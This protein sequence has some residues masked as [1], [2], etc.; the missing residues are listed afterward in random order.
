[1]CFRSFRNLVDCEETR[2]LVST[3]T[4][5]LDLD[6][7]KAKNSAYLPTYIYGLRNLHPF[8]VSTRALINALSSQI[9]IPSEN[10]SAFHVGIAL[11]GLRG[12]DNT[13][14]S[15]KFLVDAVTK[16]LI[17][18]QL[19]L[20]KHN[21]G[22][23]FYAMEHFSATINDDTTQTLIRAIITKLFKMIDPEQE[24][25]ARLTLKFVSETL[26]QLVYSSKTRVPLSTASDAATGSFKE[27][28]KLYDDDETEERLYY[29]IIIHCMFYFVNDMTSA[30]DLVRTLLAKDKIKFCKRFQKVA[31]ERRIEVDLHG[32][33]PISAALIVKCL[34]E[35]VCAVELDEI[36]SIHYHIGN[37]HHP[38]ADRIQVFEVVKQL[39]TSPEFI[40]SHKF[41]LLEE[42][43]NSHACIKL[44]RSTTHIPITGGS[45]GCLGIPKIG[46]SPTT[47]RTNHTMSL[48]IRESRKRLKDRDEITNPNESTMGIQSKFKKWEC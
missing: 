48:R 6:K 1:M 40:Y 7:T 9:S 30:K 44:L 39:V 27:M 23:I 14:K 28:R 20:N 41:T 10:W 38:A 25:P 11:Q 42:G 45:P 21:L 43:N 46:Q 24:I 36:D 33:L 4:S 32:Q 34:T 18:S 35:D 12:V 29:S 16:Q 15:G 26:T 47:I 2:E 3:I 5:K 19:K 13:S 31:T 37:G 17:K 22:H 8:E